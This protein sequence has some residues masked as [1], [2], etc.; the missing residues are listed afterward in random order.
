MCLFAF[1]SL[2][3]LGTCPQNLMPT[4]DVEPWE[5]HQFSQWGMLKFT[6]KGNFLTIKIAYENSWIKNPNGGN[7]L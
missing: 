4:Q 7:M 3:E 5:N 2:G 6:Y 1:L